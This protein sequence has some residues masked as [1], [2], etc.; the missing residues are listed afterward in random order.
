L[1]RLAGSKNGTG[2]A[3]KIV[4]GFAPASA[5]RLGRET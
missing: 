4:R 2:V 3:Q 1:S 5:D